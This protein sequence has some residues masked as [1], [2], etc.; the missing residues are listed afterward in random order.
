MSLPSGTREDVT[1]VGAEYG[2]G[3]DEDADV[4][5][6]EDEID[7]MERRTLWWFTLASPLPLL[8]VPVPV[9]VPER[10]PDGGMFA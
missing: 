7:E 8:S 3:V 6:A 9:P 2:F 1:P 4:S 10:E 5:A